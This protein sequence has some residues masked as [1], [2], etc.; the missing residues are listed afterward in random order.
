M[1]GGCLFNLHSLAKHIDRGDYRKNHN[2]TYFLCPISGAVCGLIVVILLL[3]GVLTLGLAEQAG[4]AVMEHP[5]KL[6]PFIAVAIVAG[7]GSRQFKR[8]LDEIA[9]TIFKTNEKNLKIR[10][11]Y[12]PPSEG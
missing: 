12:Q 9:D 4:I 3:G 11:A 10:E 1:I 5:G 7:Y 2:V 6:M 8:K